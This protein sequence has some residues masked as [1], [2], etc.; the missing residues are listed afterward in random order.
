[1]AQGP[2]RMVSTAVAPQLRYVASSVRAGRPRR[3]IADA[4]GAAAAP[5]QPRGVVGTC[6]QHVG[7]RHVASR[8]ATLW[9]AARY[10]RARRRSDGCSTRAAVGRPVRTDSHADSQ[11]GCA[12]RPG[13]GRRAQRVDRRTARRA[14]GRAGRGVDPWRVRLPRW[15]LTHAPRKCRGAGSQLPDLGHLCV[16]VTSLVQVGFVVRP[17]CRPMR[18]W[19]GLRVAAGWIPPAGRRSPFASGPVRRR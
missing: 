15:P 12:T 8:P 1:M 11:Q 9:S 5:C 7:W 2:D 17:G 10:E 19:R 14:R 6:K 18:L 3:P 16:R 4:T 13:V